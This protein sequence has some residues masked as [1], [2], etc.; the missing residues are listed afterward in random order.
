MN[1]PTAIYL[2]AVNMS[3]DDETAPQVLAQ[4]A[5]FYACPGVV[6]GWLAGGVDG[7]G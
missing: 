5:D 4:G 7:V 6:G 1:F 2:V 3:L